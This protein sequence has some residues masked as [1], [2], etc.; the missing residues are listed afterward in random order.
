MT[1]DDDEAAQV[2]LTPQVAEDKRD[3]SESEDEDHHEDGE[4][5][6][7]KRESSENKKG[8]DKDSWKC[9][10]CSVRNSSSVNKCVACNTPRQGFEDVNAD[11]V[12]TSKASFGLIGAG[13]FSFGGGTGGGAIG[14]TLDSEEIAEHAE[15]EEKA[16]K[17]FS[18][19]DNSLL[20]L[21]EIAERAEEEE[22]ARKA[23]RKFAKIE[24]GVS[25]II[26]STFGK[27]IESM[28]TTYCE[29]E[30][31]S[32]LK[33]LRK[34]GDKIH[35]LD[36]L[37]WYINWLFGDESE[38][39][40]E[41]YDEDE[42]KT[43]KGESSMNKKGSGSLFQV[44]TI[45]KALNSSSFQGSE[46]TF[47]D[48]DGTP[49]EDR[50]LKDSN[51]SLEGLLLQTMDVDMNDN[52]A[53]EEESQSSESESKQDYQEEIRDS[54]EG[55]VKEF[56]VDR[57]PRKK[58]CSSQ[59]IH[60]F[61]VWPPI[62]R[63][64]NFEQRQFSGLSIGSGFT[65]DFLSSLGKDD[66]VSGD[67]FIRHP[68]E[69]QT[70]Y[71]IRYDG[72]SSLQLHGIYMPP[73]PANDDRFEP[74]SRLPDGAPNMPSRVIDLAPC[75]PRK[76]SSMMEEDDASVDFD[77]VESQN[78]PPEVWI[79]PM[80]GTNPADA[81]WKVKRVWALENEGEK[82]E[83]LV[84]NQKLFSKIK[85]LVGAPDSAPPMDGMP[86]MPMRSW[87]VQRVVEKRGKIE[88]TDVEKQL[89]NEELD[90]N[91]E[92]MTKEA[93][94]EIEENKIALEEAKMRK[95]ELE[96]KM[97]DAE[98]AI[99]NS[100][101]VLVDRASTRGAPWS[102]AKGD[103]SRI[104]FSPL[105]VAR[106]RQE[107]LESS[108]A[109]PVT[110]DRV[111]A[112]EASWSPGKGDQ[113]LGLTV[114][115]P[116]LN[117]RELDAAASPQPT[118]ARDPARAK[119]L[120]ETSDDT[121]LAEPTSEA[122]E[123]D[124]DDSDEPHSAAPEEGSPEFEQ[125]VLEDEV[126]Q[127]APTSEV[128]KDKDDDNSYMADESDEDSDYQDNHGDKPAKT[129]FL[130]NG[131]TFDKITKHTKS[132]VDKKE[133]ASIKALQD[134]TP[135]EGLKHLVI[136]MSKNLPKLHCFL[137]AYDIVKTMATELK[138]DV[139]TFISIRAWDVN[140]DVLDKE[141]LPRVFYR[142]FEAC[143]QVVVKRGDEVHHS[144]F[145]QWKNSIKK[146]FNEIDEMRK[147][148][149][150]SD[151]RPFKVISLD[152]FRSKLTEVTQLYHLAYVSTKNLFDKFIN[153]KSQL[154]LLVVQVYSGCKKQMMVV[155][156][157]YTIFRFLEGNPTDKVIQDLMKTPH[158]TLGYIHEHTPN[159]NDCFYH[160]SVVTQMKA[161]LLEEE[162]TTDDELV[163]IDV[164][165]SM[166]VER[167]AQKGSNDI[168]YQQESES[169]AESVENVADSAESVAESVAKTNPKSIANEKKQIMDYTIV[170]Y[171]VMKEYE[172]I[173]KAKKKRKKDSSASKKSRKKIRLTQDPPVDHA[174]FVITAPKMS[175][176]GA[177]PLLD[178]FH[179]DENKAK[180][181]SV[182]WKELQPSFKKVNNLALFDPSRYTAKFVRLA[183]NE[184]VA[185]L[186]PQLFFQ[187]ADNSLRVVAVGPVELYVHDDLA[188][189]PHWMTY[190]ADMLKMMETH[191]LH[192]VPILHSELRH[193][194]FFIIRAEHHVF[195]KSFAGL[196]ISFDLLFRFL[197]KHGG[198][199]AMRDGDV[200]N[201]MRYDFGS[202]A[203]SY[204]SHEDDATTRKELDDANTRKELICS[205]PH[206]D[207]G[208]K[209]LEDF[210]NGVL[211]QQIG[212]LVDCMQDAVDA[213]CFE[214]GSDLPMNDSLRNS[215]FSIP[216]RKAL[217]A[218][219][220]RGETYSLQLK[221]LSLGHTVLEHVDNLN[222][223][224]PDY[225]IT[226]S[227]GFIFV[228]TNNQL[229]RL[230]VLTYGRKACGQ[231]MERN[232]K[233]VVV[234]QMAQ[235]YFRVLDKAYKD[236]QINYGANLPVDF[237]ITWDKYR[238]FFID[239]SCNWEWVHVNKTS[240]VEVNC[241]QLPT[242]IT[243]DYWL[244]PAIHRLR[245][246][247]EVISDQLLL[248]QIVLIALLQS[249]WSIFWVVT[250]KMLQEREDLANPAAYYY[251]L[252]KHLFGGFVG[253]FAQRF[254]FSSV[255]FEEF[256]LLPPN[257]K[258]N[259]DRAILELQAALA[260]AK[261]RTSVSSVI[262]ITYLRD[263]AKRIPNISDFR[264]QFLM[265]IY[266]LSGLLNKNLKM[267]D[268][269]FPSEGM[270]SWRALIKAGYDPN[271]F[272]NTMK[273]VS[274]YI[275]LKLPRDGLMENVLCEGDKV[276]KGG[277]PS[278]D[279]FFFGQN[280]YNYWGDKND[281]CQVFCKQFGEREW[282]LASLVVETDASGYSISDKSFHCL[283]SKASDLG[284][285]MNNVYL[286]KN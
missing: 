115:S 134:W 127:V 180:Q 41:D 91:I 63:F 112:G 211:L 27:M 281:N 184:E 223:P 15:E 219:K 40:D 57:V 5:K 213:C 88:D 153:S 133:E 216:L 233:V 81:M 103:Q 265:P 30:H 162:T 158:Q 228:D 161:R 249:N 203:R 59:N 93:V 188:T 280:L 227:L 55:S 250:G 145:W 140:L 125:H 53:E 52:P 42:D 19:D 262:T 285:R 78:K 174:P 271:E 117:R 255:N 279:I 167:L 56:V 95:K 90:A 1:H 240:A 261:S 156:G 139:A 283:A 43:D 155:T 48:E 181:G 119:A 18:T 170:K 236:F 80:C 194:D 44:D 51:P 74:T 61:A 275:G 26:V 176:P 143:M 111:P 157:A 141:G 54:K 159:D 151:H 274:K 138:F 209:T 197:L 16:R 104:G 96:A 23:F 204:F 92:V 171:K 64:H 66:D 146:L 205:K 79:T 221:C 35:E 60:D 3:K 128:A 257:G 245:Q 259:L 215:L 186:A 241:V 201:G 10:V 114:I 130:S 254:R 87:H 58:R 284:E 76:R 122:V 270:G 73:V 160:N 99:P 108:L 142:R 185:A 8:L 100:A 107:G 258:Q 177:V 248:L 154:E 116:V 45:P 123:K 113:L 147:N 21:E 37:A 235:S 29:E 24:N 38:S 183:T 251:C 239:K 12:P 179:L 238:L 200:S 68:P 148:L 136:R 220:T 269:A 36:F 217:G 253:G 25:T 47:M 225:S 214:V 226:S 244:S 202:G 277:D 169:V 247:S 164:M 14:S 9:D 13:G 243:R 246:L 237:E 49:A 102:P 212:D 252:S 165:A 120:L 278:T 86:K 75:A 230:N 232:S 89:D 193:K 131:L 207:T 195:M 196:Q 94:T 222:C 109:A 110:T 62:I 22:K 168:L 182:Q 229:W 7:H 256:Y 266:V 190:K 69:K 71:R 263:L 172:K 101:P 218:S 84:H 178:L 33:K 191:I 199:N 28:G 268:I 77:Q 124:D 137:D 210:E 224:W 20:D 206:H 118:G 97:L 198:S 150:S 65:Y 70:S 286:N 105:P 4:G 106:A 46:P 83:H 82:E 11:K 234:R 126:A 39:E 166:D 129:K 85:T 34:P 173:V 144:L 267:A 189:V 132:I 273:T 6:T 72:P 276:S 32:T 192:T 282:A 31:Y 2:A 272:Q 231:L 149:P 187:V 17:A 264:I 152:R 242:A 50:I 135:S 260:W 163:S 67:D 175:V 208:I 121:V 98:K